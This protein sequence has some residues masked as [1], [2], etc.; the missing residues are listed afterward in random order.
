MVSEITVSGKEFQFHPETSFFFF[1]FLI[2]KSDLGGEKKNATITFMEW[3]ELSDLNHLT[4]TE[5]INI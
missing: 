2:D 4:V 3:K 5:K 1:F